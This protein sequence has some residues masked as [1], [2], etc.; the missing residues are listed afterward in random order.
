MT[1]ALK[2]QF[3][4]GLEGSPQG[5]KAR[6]FDEH[7]TALTP[8]MATGDFEGCVE[9]QARALTTFRPDLLVGSSFGGAVVVELLQRGL[10]P[11]PRNGPGGRQQL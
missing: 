10:W 9:T 3:A 8:A 5:T 1:A 11:G 4:H 2:L 7:F 6:L